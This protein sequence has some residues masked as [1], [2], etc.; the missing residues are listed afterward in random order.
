MGT[1][2]SWLEI[3]GPRL[4]S[5]SGPVLSQLKQS[6]AGRDGGQGVGGAVFALV[7]HLPAGIPRNPEVGQP[8]RPSWWWPS[9]VEPS[10]RA[11]YR[12]ITD[13]LLRV[14][15]ECHSGAEATLPRRS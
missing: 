2:I 8:T 15:H 4:N 5:L 13:R 11:Q 1:P 14:C 6:W 12:A 7:R 10:D 3:L 9:Q